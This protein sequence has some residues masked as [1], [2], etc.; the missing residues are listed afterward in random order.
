[1]PL[2][3]L[4]VLLLLT[5]PAV[6]AGDRR[7]A[8][9]RPPTTNWSTQSTNH[10]PSYVTNRTI[11]DWWGNGITSEQRDYLI[12]LGEHNNSRNSF[13]TLAELKHAVKYREKEL[14]TEQSQYYIQIWI[15]E[16]DYSSG[17]E[18]DRRERIVNCSK[19]R[20]PVWK[21][22]KHH[23]N[24]I[25]TNGKSGSEKR[26]YKWDNTHDDIE[27]YNGRGEHL[28]SMDPRTGKMYKGPVSGRDIRSQ[29]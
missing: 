16:N 11:Y 20:S 15:D 10:T 26:F 7:R 2:F 25:K 4:P 8:N 13:Y 5:A 23:K 9:V 3:F 14:L 6:A 28:G 27:V 19:S 12:K 17:E 18:R 1:M 24:D 22:L 29:L 21:G